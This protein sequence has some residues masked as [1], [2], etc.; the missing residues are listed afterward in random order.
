MQFVFFNPLVFSVL[1]MQIYSRLTVDNLKSY[2]FKY[3]LSARKA[4]LLP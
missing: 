1:V 3:D 2:V 4:A